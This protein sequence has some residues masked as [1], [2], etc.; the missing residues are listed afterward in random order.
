MRGIWRKPSDRIAL[1]WGD[2]VGFGSILAL[3]KALEWHTICCFE[4]FLVLCWGEA[5]RNR[6][7]SAVDGDRMVK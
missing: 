3:T 6:A 5:L 4:F 2:G 1:L 7:V